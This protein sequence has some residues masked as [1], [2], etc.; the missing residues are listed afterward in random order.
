ML[1]GFRHVYLMALN[2]AMSQYP[3]E[4]EGAWPELINCVHLRAFVLAPA[5]SAPQR[6]YFHYSDSVK[7]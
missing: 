5:H 3:H 6:A 4:A 2:V 7:S 1:V